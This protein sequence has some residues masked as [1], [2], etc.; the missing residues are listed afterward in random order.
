MDFYATG[1]QTKRWDVFINHRGIDTKRNVVGLL[2]D[3]LTRHK[4]HPFL[5][6]K[7]MNP[8]DKLFDNI[9]SA[10]RN[11]KIGVAVFSPRYCESHFCLHELATLME[12]KKKV[13]PIFVDIKPSELH[14]MDF[15]GRLKLKSSRDLGVL[16]RRPSTQWVLHLTRLMESFTCRSREEDDLIPLPALHGLRGNAPSTAQFC[17]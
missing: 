2:Y 12:S 17:R 11:C 7:T 14:V 5:D 9:D 1:G 13:I 8:G 15:N 3:N 6:S 16:L 4:L 10:I